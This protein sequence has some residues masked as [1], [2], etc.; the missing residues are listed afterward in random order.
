MSNENEHI[1]VERVE[2]EI[3]N[4]VPRRPKRAAIKSTTPDQLPNNAVRAPG[5]EKLL[6]GSDGRF[7][8]K[9]TS[10][11]QMAEVIDQYFADCV[12]MVENPQTGETEYFWIDPPTIPGLAL[13]LGMTS[14][15][16]LE[17]AKLDEFEEIITDAKLRIEEYT[18]KALHAN[19]KATGLIFILK[20]MGWQDNRIVT[21]AP[22]NR[23]EAAKTP[24]QLAAL[25]QQD[26][27]D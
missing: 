21:Y 14:R 3:V 19:P 23:L 8:A 27:V 13:A 24:E 17:Y 6:R 1:E 12:R 5:P 22:P 11:E 9:F 4:A 7:K 25:V 15:N 18:A 2:A 20:N 10:P 16:L 26:V